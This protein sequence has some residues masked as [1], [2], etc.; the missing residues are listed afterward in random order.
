[1]SEQPADISDSGPPV[2][3]HSTNCNDLADWLERLH[4][5]RYEVPKVRVD[6]VAKNPAEAMHSAIQTMQEQIGDLL[7]CM[8]KSVNGTHNRY[9]N[10]QDTIRYLRQEDPSP[11]PSPLEGERE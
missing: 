7:D 3:W 2:M 4:Q 6:L 1:M 5:L 9:R 8:V 10:T 11:R